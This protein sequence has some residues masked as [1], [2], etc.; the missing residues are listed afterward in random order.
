M[1]C[2]RPT[3]QSLFYTTESGRPIHSRQLEKQL[4]NFFEIGV[5]AVF[6]ITNICEGKAVLSF[7]PGKADIHYCKTREHRFG[8]DWTVLYGKPTHAG[9]RSIHEQQLWNMP[10][11]GHIGRKAIGSSVHSVDVDMGYSAK[12]LR[13]RYNLTSSIHLSISSNSCPFRS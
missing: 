7:L 13:A 10:L 9:F 1:C 2:R 8:W 11:A 12:T 6:W 3:I 4:P 5:S